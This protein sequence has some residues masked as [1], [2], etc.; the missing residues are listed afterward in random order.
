MLSSCLCCRVEQGRRCGI[1]R[2]ECPS[3][4]KELS[5]GRGGRQLGSRRRRYQLC[6]GLC[7]LAE[8]AQG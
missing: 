2:S 6:K 8:W 4:L 3:R 7:I 5:S 1:V